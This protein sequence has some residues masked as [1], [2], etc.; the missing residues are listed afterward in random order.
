MRIRMPSGKEVDC[1]FSY[2]GGVLAEGA[3]HGELVEATTDELAKLKAAGYTDL[4]ETLGADEKATHGRIVEV[5]QE[6]MT[7]AELE[8]RLEEI[9]KQK[10]DITDQLPRASG[11]QKDE[12]VLT[13]R[14]TEKNEALV[15]ELLQGDDDWVGKKAKELHDAVGGAG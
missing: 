9:G 13:L 8:A 7:S 1:R 14:E 15:V 11:R 3:E 10:R 5:D 2:N 6:P 12:L 4:V